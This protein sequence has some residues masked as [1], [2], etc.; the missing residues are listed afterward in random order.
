MTA[1]AN[2]ENQQF[3]RLTAI[4]YVGER[5]WRCKC[6]CGGETLAVSRNLLNGNTKSCG[7]IQRERASETHKTHGM[8]LT[9]EYRIWRT[10]KARC[11]N[12]KNANYSRYGGRGI[13]VCDR[14]L[15]SFENFLADMGEKPEGLS[16]DRIDVDGDY[17]PKNCRWA[18]VGEQATNRRNNRYVEFDG[19]KLTI[20]EW[21]RVTNLKPGLIKNRLDAGWSAEKALTTPTRN[22]Q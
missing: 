19:K 11:L 16:L 15:E 13:K 10:M 14:W 6:D 4:E 7:C 3:G 1:R 8:T 12:E 2:L 18:T 20:S 21:A 22:Q 5:R 9:S 17:T